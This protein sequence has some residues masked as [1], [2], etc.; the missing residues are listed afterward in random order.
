MRTATALS[1]QAGSGEGRLPDSYRHEHLPGN[2]HL[3]HDLP[4]HHPSAGG[5]DFPGNHT[6]D[7]LSAGVRKAASHTDGHFAGLRFRD[8]FADSERNLSCFLFGDHPTHIVRDPLRYRLRFHAADTVRDFLDN[9]LRDH[10]RNCGGDLAHDHFRNVSGHLHGAV[11]THDLRHHDSAGNLLLYDFG[12]PHAA[13]DD[14]RRA[15]DRTELRPPGAKDQP[16][17]HQAWH[18]LRLHLP[19]ADCPLNGLSSNFRAQDGP[20]T[21]LIDGFGDTFEHGL[22]TFLLNGFS[23]GPEHRAGDLS[24]TVLPDRSLDGAYAVAVLPLNHGPLDGPLFFTHHCFGDRAIHRVLFVAV[25]CLLN[26][27]IAGRLHVL[28]D[29]FIHGALRLVLFRFPHRFADRLHAGLRGD[30]AGGVA[31]RHGTGRSGAAGVRIDTAHTSLDGRS[32]KNTQSGK[33][34][35]STQEHLQP[36]HFRNPEKLNIAQKDGIRFLLSGTAL[37]AAGF[38]RSDYP[39]PATTLKGKATGN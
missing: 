11:L 29:V 31:G 14:S 22:A 15:L 4:G 18:C 16:R 28:P 3:L 32:A 21:L 25:S 12:A 37:V 27:T 1:G 23:D 13:G 6:T 2:W 30:T 39:T 8:D 34:R 38:C 26:Q 20:A 19:F 24:L 17:H 36:E 10:S 9:L 7:F 5:R 35:K 33:N